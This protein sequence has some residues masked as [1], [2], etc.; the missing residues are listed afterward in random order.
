MWAWTKVEDALPPVNEQVI[1]F[2]V[3][4]FDGFVGDTVMAITRMSDKDRFFYRNEVEPYWIE[5]WMFFSQII[6]SLTG[7]RCQK[8]QRRDN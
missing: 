7:C 4:I 3:G 8:H 6:K 1:I 2:A 5:P